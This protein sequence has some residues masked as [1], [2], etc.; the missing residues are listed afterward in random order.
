MFDVDID[1]ADR[2]KALMGLHH[3]DAMLINKN[4]QISRHP[5]GVYFQD[6]P[7]NPITGLCAF[8]YKHAEDLGYFKLDFLNQTIYREVRDEAHLDALM[9]TPPPWELLDEQSFVEQLAHIANHFDIVQS[10]APRSVSDLAIVLALIRPGKRYLVGKK[11]STIESEVWKLDA[12][13]EYV[14]KHAHAISYSVLIVVQMNLIVE[15]MLNDHDGI[16]I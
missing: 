8:D 13:D 10:I 6:I 4:E 5:S 15:R 14:F 7:T 16:S 3:V 11:R 9:N 2:D 12:K 1:F